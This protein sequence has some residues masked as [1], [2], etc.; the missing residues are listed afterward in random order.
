MTTATQWR[1]RGDVMEAC[2]CDVTCPCNFGGDPTQLPCQA[3]LGLSIQ[4]GNYGNTRLDN[5]N[6]VFVLSFP[7]NPF[8]GNW[9]I[10]TYIDQRASPEQM[11]ALGAIFSGQAGSWFAAVSGLITNPLPPKQV[12][13]SFEKVDGNARITVPGLLEVGGEAVPNPMG[14]ELDTKVSALAVPFYNGEASVRRA[15]VLKVTD[16]DLSFE[17]AGTS[18]LI[19]QFDYSGP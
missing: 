5:L 11:E 3:I 15:S 12:P 2:S 17:Y 19:G 14:G 16:P 6:A 9:T 7:G 4:E 10:G 13:I 1:M 8:D 18:S